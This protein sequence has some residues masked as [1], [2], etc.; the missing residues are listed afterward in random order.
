MDDPVTFCS[1]GIDHDSKRP[2]EMAPQP[3]FMSGLSERS[4]DAISFLTGQEMR[5]ADY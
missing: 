3:T 1:S 4:V 2:F 5:I